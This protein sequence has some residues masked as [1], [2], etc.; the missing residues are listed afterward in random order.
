MSPTG[1]LRR[2]DSVWRARARSKHEME[3]IGDDLLDEVRVC[4]AEHQGIDG[5]KD[6]QSDGYSADHERTD[7]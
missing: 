1:R 5:C 3:E 2:R 4:A 7:G 6:D